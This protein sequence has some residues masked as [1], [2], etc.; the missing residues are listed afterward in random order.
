MVY[1]YIGNLGNWKSGTLETWMAEGLGNLGTWDPGKCQFFIW[2]LGKCNKEKPT[3]GVPPTT[4]D[5]GAWGGQDV[6]TDCGGPMIPNPPWGPSRAL[7][8][9]TVV[10]LYNYTIGILVYWY[11]G[12][13]VYWYI[14]ILVWYICILEYWRQY[15]PPD[16]G[17]RIIYIYIYI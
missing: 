15:R 5:L 12:I 11:I 2:P 3:T 7:Y 8:N 1:W 17:R 14:G 4:G 16:L 9:Y 13:L 6:E 10:Q